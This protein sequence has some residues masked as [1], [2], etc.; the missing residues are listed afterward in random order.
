MQVWDAQDHSQLCSV[1]MKS[2]MIQGE[3]TAVLYNEFTK[4]IAITT[5][6]L[7]VLNLREH[8]SV[9]SE[10]VLFH[11]LP[12]C[13]SESPVG[14]WSFTYPV[15]LSIFHKNKTK[16]SDIDNSYRLIKCN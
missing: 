13:H 11:C 15:L 5:D 7:S 2:H 4:A 1:G 3:M 12:K 14:P 9:Q 16:L 10:S 8:R 6:C